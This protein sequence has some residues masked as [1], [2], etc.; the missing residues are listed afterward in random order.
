MRRSAVV[1]LV[2]APACFYVT[3]VERAERWDLDGDGAERPD[4]CDDTDPALAEPEVLY[5]DA[6]GDGFGD[7]TERLSACGEVVGFV[8][9]D[10]DCDDT[11]SVAF[12]GAPERCDDRD[13]NCDELIDEGLSQIDWYVDADGDGHGDENDEDPVED[14]GPPDGYSPDASDCDDTTEAVNPDLD[15]VCGNG[16]DDNCRGG[17]DEGC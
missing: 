17:I 14:C 5:A 3:D 8:R 2:F 6:D 7:A 11:S 15:E 16:V 10:T 9:D 1:L 4:D 12:P 13:N